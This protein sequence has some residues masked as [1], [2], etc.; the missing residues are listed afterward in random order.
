MVE[1]THALAAI[2]VQPAAPISECPGVTFFRRRRPALNLERKKTNALTMLSKTANSLKSAVS[3]ER[4]IH[5]PHFKPGFIVLTF[6][7]LRWTSSCLG[8]T[9]QQI[10]VPR[11]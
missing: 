11:P 7:T 10:L 3:P 1:A 8:Q 2:I 4:Q 5:G 6:V 9:L